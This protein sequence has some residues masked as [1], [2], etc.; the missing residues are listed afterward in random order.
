MAARKTK[1]T[2][3]LNM[4]VDVFSNFDGVLNYECP[5][6]K[7]SFIF[8][9]IEASDTMTVA[10]LKTLVTQ[11]PRFFKDGW[12][13]I[14]DEEVSNYLRLEKFGSKVLNK[15]DFQELFTEKPDKIEEILIN[16]ENE[17]SRQNAFAFAQ[18]E[19][20]NGRLRDHFVIKAIEKGLG[21]QLDPNS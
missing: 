20:V 3:D 10:Q 15:N 12:L 18:D 4:F 2:I 13:T 9:E 7:E 21:K 11:K 5:K 19:Y 8:H 14:K 17:S 6:T 1:P 16:L